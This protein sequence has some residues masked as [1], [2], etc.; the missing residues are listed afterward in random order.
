MGCG[1]RFTGRPQPEVFSSIAISRMISPI[2]E[3]TRNLFDGENRARRFQ[4]DMLSS[5][6]KEEFS[7]F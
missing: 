6:P 3:S 5:R 4:Y 7:D 2:I 1:H